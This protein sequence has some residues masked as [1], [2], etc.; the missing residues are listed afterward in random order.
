M[1]PGSVKC[2]G[3]FFGAVK[4]FFL[5]SQTLPECVSRWPHRLNISSRAASAE[6]NEHHSRLCPNEATA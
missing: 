3:F 2:P 4:T 5:A 6:T 1:S